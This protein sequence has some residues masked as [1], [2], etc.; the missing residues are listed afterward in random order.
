MDYG[1]SLEDSDLTQNEPDIVDDVLVHDTLPPDEQTD[2]EEVFQPAADSSS[3]EEMPAYNE[4]QSAQTFQVSER[5][6]H[7]PNVQA[8]LRNAATLKNAMAKRNKKQ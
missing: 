8:I 7:R 3:D 5:V 6:K 2:H 1:S 4:P